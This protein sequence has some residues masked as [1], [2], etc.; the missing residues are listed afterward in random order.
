VITSQREQYGVTVHLFIGT[1]RSPDKITF[2]SLIF[3]VDY[4]ANCRGLNSLFPLKSVS[5]F[6]IINV[7]SRSFF[8]YSFRASLSFVQIAPSYHTHLHLKGKTSC[9]GL[10]H[11]E[12]HVSLVFEDL[13]KRKA[14]NSHR[15]VRCANHQQTLPTAR[16]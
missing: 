7:L 11:T 5:P 8:S 12:K 4:K 1:G 10:C 9:N 14:P 3:T 16:K 2:M 15:T 13:R 6:T